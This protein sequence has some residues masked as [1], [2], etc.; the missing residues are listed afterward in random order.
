MRQLV[1]TMFIRNKCPSFH[2]SWKENL[3]KH[4][5]VSRYY[6]TDCSL[7]TGL[8]CIP[9]YVAAWHNMK[10]LYLWRGNELFKINIK[11]K[12]K[13][14]ATKYPQQK[15]SSYITVW[16]LS[17]KPFLYLFLTDN[18]KLD[19]MPTNIKLKIQACFTLYFKFW[20]G[21]SVK[22]CKIQL[23]VL[24]FLVLHKVLHQQISFFY[25]FLELHPTLSEKNFCRKFSFFN[26]FTQISLIPKIW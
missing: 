20:E 12:W 13:N 19:G 10:I 23:P 26:G 1:Y 24:L 4:R 21:T 6:E 15:L 7:L 8:F 5:K 9:I 17:K 11:F 16:L 3:V 14:A 22:S 25:N 2:L 18:I